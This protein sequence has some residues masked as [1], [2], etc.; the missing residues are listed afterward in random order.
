M[1]GLAKTLGESGIAFVQFLGYDK[2][3]GLVKS[4][5]GFVGDPLRNF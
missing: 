3:A 5:E 2:V 4:L 1:S